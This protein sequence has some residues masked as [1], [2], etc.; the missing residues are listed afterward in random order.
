MVLLLMMVTAADAAPMT[1]KEVQLL[2][3][4]GIPDREIIGDVQSRKLAEPAS[5]NDVAALKVAGA[6]PQLLAV[7]QSPAARMD[8][9][10]AA[11][12]AAQKQKDADRQ[13]LAALPRL[14]IFGRTNQTPQ[15]GV[16]VSCGM[17]PERITSQEE[18]CRDAVHFAGTPPSFMKQGDQVP[19][20]NCEASVIGTFT[21]T[22]E[23][24]GKKTVMPEVVLWRDLGIM[25]T[26][27]PDQPR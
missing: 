14:W 1:L 13:K 12:L 8:A 23:F 19:W 24:D 10:Q 22:N 21:Y 20:V 26:A 27:G 7:L 18:R 16:I 11:T 2:L 25:N 6:S 3:R 15:G 17:K 5:E 4:S 9:A